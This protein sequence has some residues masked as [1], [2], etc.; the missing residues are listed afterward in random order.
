[1]ATPTPTRIVW[2][3]RAEAPDPRFIPWRIAGRYFESCNCDAICPCRM[4]GGRPGG[5][6]THG[7]CY[8]V[9]SWAVGEGRAGTVDLAGLK[10]ALTMEYSDDQPGSP[11]RFVLHV[12][13]EAGPDEGD[14][15]AGILLG[16]LGG[17]VLRLPWLRKPSELVERRSSTIELREAGKGYEL[18]VGAAVEVKAVRPVETAEE[19][20]CIVP[21]YDRP[22]TELYADRLRVDDP[23]FDWELAE[24]CAFTSSFDY[25]S[26]G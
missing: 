23:P 1:L 25:R 12:D 24:T 7:V 10:A 3:L 17:E 22:G 18:R 6:S 19:V 15:L 2:R 4:V 8:G 5:R 11:W 14:A 13:A 20:A 21:G 16:D 26:D 9:L